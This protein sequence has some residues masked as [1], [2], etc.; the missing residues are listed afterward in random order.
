MQ[1]VNP[2]LLHCRQILY[3]QSP[4]RGKW[5]LT[6]VPQYFWYVQWMSPN[7]A[8]MYSLDVQ[9]PAIAERMGPKGTATS[10]DL[11]RP[12]PLVIP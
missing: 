10:C 2:G 11:D 12:L 7:R 3:C 1:A 5:Y 4:Q 9:G 6:V 8:V